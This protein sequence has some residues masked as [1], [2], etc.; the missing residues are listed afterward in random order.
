MITLTFFTQ[1]LQRPPGSPLSVLNTKQVLLCFIETLLVAVREN[2][3]DSD[4]QGPAG[5]SV[6]AVSWVQ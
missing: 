3:T 6:T 4:Q 5:G 2:E 1:R